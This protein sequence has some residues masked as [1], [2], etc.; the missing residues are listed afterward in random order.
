[1]ALR[2]KEEVI[3]VWEV[4]EALPQLDNQPLITNRLLK[5]I[6]QWEEILDIQGLEVQATAKVHQKATQA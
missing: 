2:S 5:D 4:P 6:H 3:Q 1:M